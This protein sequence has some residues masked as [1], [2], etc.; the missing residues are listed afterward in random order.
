MNLK[1]LRSNS[2]LTLLL[3][4][5]A[6]G[7]MLGIYLPAARANRSLQDELLL[8][9]Q[10]VLGSASIAGQIRQI[11]QGLRGVREYV[12]QWGGK[13]PPL[14][15]LP[16]VY[17]EI[18]Y[19]TAASGAALIELEPQPAASYDGLAQVPVAFKGRGSHAQLLSLLRQ[20]EQ[21]DQLIWVE[22]LRLARAAADTQDI[23]CDLVL[24]VFGDKSGKS[25]YADSAA[26]R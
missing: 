8:R 7:Y 26:D 17:G 3:V 2:M 4:I 22:E 21:V 25:D 10:F 23:E 14:A 24:G 13:V 12:D 9:Q 19:V 11:E 16:L 1:L 5:G 6:G 15:E 20:I 18:S